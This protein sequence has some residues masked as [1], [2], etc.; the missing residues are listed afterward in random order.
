MTSGYT[1]GEALIASLVAGVTG[2]AAAQVTRG[3]WKPIGSGKAA[4]YA[5]IHTEPVG[6]RNFTS[7]RTPVDRWLTTV[8]VWRRYVDDGTSYTQLGAYVEDIVAKIDKYPHLGDGSGYVE[9]STAEYGKVQEMWKRGGGPAWL[10]QDV[11][12]TW[13]GR[14]TITYSD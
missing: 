14:Q 9:E 11:L 13:T 4:V 5:I 12:I 3:N 1:D 2:F 7:P 10:R 8:E 6:R